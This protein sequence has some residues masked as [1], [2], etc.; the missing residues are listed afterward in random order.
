MDEP[1][2]A[3]DA[4]TRDQMN[5]EIQ[6]IWMQSERTILFVTHSISEAV[7]LA[8]RIILLS[9]RPGRVHSVT[10]VSFDRPRDMRLQTTLEFQSIVRDLREELEEMG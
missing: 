9:P 3:L 8:D 1:F 6:R 10:D 5:I 7:F 2:G 4:M